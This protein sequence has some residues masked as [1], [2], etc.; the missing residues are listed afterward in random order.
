MLSSQFYVCGEQISPQG[1]HG[2]ACLK[3]A[4]RQSRHYYLN[5]TKSSG[6]SVLEPVGI[7]REDGRRPDDMS[8]IPWKRGQLLVWG[9]TCSD[10]V[11]PNVRMQIR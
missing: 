5:E 7:L 4:G 1:T 6:P 2:L 3:T 10:T 11:A 9:S 8:I